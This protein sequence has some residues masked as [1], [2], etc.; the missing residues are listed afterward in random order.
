MYCQICEPLV[1][2]LGVDFTANY[3]E[4]EDLYT[5]EYYCPAC[6]TLYECTSQSGDMVQENL[7]IIE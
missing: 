4:K 5:R 3:N 1:K 2:L 6:D 7:N